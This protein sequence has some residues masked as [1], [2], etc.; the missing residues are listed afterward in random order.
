MS[1]PSWALSITAAAADLLLWTRRARD[2]DRLVQQ[3]WANEGSA[4]LSAYVGS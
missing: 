3:L 1:V 2:I 4:A